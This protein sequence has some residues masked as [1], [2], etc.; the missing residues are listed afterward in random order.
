MRFRSTTSRVKP[1]VVAK[2]RRTPTQ[3]YTQNWPA[4]REQ[5]KKRDGNRCTICGSPSKLEVHHILHLSKGGRTVSSNL[6]TL[7]KTCHGRKHGH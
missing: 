1:K 5:I 6:T 3:S 2:I 7:C 4:I